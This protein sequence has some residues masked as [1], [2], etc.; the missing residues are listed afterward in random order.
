MNYGYEMIK[1]VLEMAVYSV[2][3]FQILGLK[4]KEKKCFWGIMILAH[5]LV[6]SGLWYMK[7]N[8]TVVVVVCNLLE[9][10][11]PVAVAKCRLLKGGAASFCSYM[12]MGMTFDIV[13]LVLRFVPGIGEKQENIIHIITMLVLVMVLCVI[14]S[15]HKIRFIDV[16]RISNVILLALGLFGFGVSAFISNILHDDFHSRGAVSINIIAIAVLMVSF[17]LCFTILLVISHKK[18]D[19]EQANT[20]SKS[21]IESQ[22]KYVREILGDREEIRGMYHDLDKMVLVLNAFMEGGR[23]DEAL[24]TLGQL[25]RKLNGKRHQLVYTND[26]LIDAII[27]QYTG[28]AEKQN[29]AFHVRVKAE[30]KPALQGYDFCIILSN[31]LS[32][33]IEAASAMAENRQINVLIKQNQNQWYLR[34][35]NTYSAQNSNTTF[36]YSTKSGGQHGYGIKNIREA[37]DRLGGEV[38]FGMEG[39]YVIAEVFLEEN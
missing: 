4:R 17:V 15:V 12:F 31:L 30:K 33:A 7:E 9:I 26:E 16:S 38:H 36:T 19:M 2:M 28:I 1:E 37:A 21:I 20:E 32:N 6:W 22:Q 10:G 23:Y 8:Y 18:A 24:K 29:I 13:R 14:Q 25:N 11:L 35:E 27:S 3:C 34:V 5:V 39:E